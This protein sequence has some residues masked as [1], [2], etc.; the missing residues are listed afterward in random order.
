MQGSVLDMDYLTKPLGSLELANALDQLGLRASSPEKTILVVDD[1]PDILELHTRLVECQLPDCRVLTA[2]NGREA[3]ELIETQHPHLVLLDLMMPEVDGFEVLQTMRNRDQTRNIPVIVL[4]AQVLTGNDMERLQQGV[5]AV[6]SKGLFSLNEVMVQIETT[7][8]NSKRLGSEAQRLV[9]RAIASI[10]EHYTERIS[11]ASL[12]QQLAVSEN[13]LT[14]CFRQELGISPITYLNRFRI[15]RAK[16]LLEK[17]EASIT[18]VAERVGFSDSNYFG[19][20][21]RSEVGVSPGAYQHG[22]RC[23]GR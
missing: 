20:V 2:C 19:R 14:R 3:L 16:A 13:Y 17:G 18:E 15:S 5:A 1:E 22:K 11:R 12:A 23:P 4:T 10:N 8:A 9:R 7:L 6:L 21:F